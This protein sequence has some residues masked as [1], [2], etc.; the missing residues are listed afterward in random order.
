M[1]YLFLTIS[2]LLL[3]FSCKKGAGTFVL[4]GQIEDLTFNEA[5]SD[6][7]IKLY[8]VPIGTTSLVIQDSMLLD[9][10]G[11]YQFSFPRE[12]IEKYVIK[13]NKDGYFAIQEDIYFSSLTL[14]NDNIRNFQTQAKAWVGITLLNENPEPTDI[15]TYTKQEGL[16]DCAECC[17]SDEQIFYGDL[18]TTIYCINNGNE[19]YSILYNIF[20][21][22][23]VDIIS[24][25]TPPFDTAYIN[26][27]Y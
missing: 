14:E 18:D 26:I 13:I 6:T 7:W 9:E 27:T 17:P 11:Q 1:K 20:S 19:A 24:Q 16:Q 4:K 8:K 15:L 10:S 22:N 3:V 12:Q 5:L 2:L 21:S 25:T 23:T